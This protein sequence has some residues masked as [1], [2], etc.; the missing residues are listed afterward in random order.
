[1]PAHPVSRD[2]PAWMR[3]GLT[4]AE[5]KWCTVLR[6]SL[7]RNG[8]G[9]RKTCEYRARRCLLYRRMAEHELDAIAE[10]GIADYE[11]GWEFLEETARLAAPRPDPWPPAASADPLD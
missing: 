3:K 1:M 2:G 7:E 11:R 9:D 10:F 4:K 8:F 6:N 5:R